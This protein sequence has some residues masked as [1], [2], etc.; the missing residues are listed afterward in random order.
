MY[1][2][3]YAGNIILFNLFLLGIISHAVSH[4]VIF[5]N[6]IFNDYMR[7]CDFIMFSYFEHS[8]DFHSLI[9][10]VSHVCSF[11]SLIFSGYIPERG[12][13]GLKRKGY[14]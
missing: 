7:Y 5:Q 10:K 12:I 8:V 1:M 6:M 2:M 13:T 14:F 3:V 4:L 11:C 9:F